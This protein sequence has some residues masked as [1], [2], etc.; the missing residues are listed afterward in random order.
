MKNITIKDI[1]SMAGTSKTTVSFYLNGKSDRMST[2]T[3]LKIEKIIRE[4]NYS[5]SF[6]ARS[7]TYK[8]TNL[9]GVI[10]ADIC[11]P[12]SSAIVKEID[13]AARK[14][15]YQIIVGSSKF[16]F[17]NEEKYINKMLDMGV[18]GFIIQA[19][20]KFSKF[21]DKI[22]GQGK[23]LLLLDSVNSNFKGSFVKINNFDITKEAIENLIYKGYNNFILLTRNPKISMTIQERKKAFTETLERHK[24]NY[25]V[26]LIDD[27]I[28]RENI[29]KAIDNTLKKESK[30]LIFTVDGEILQK[31]YD[32]IKDKGLNIPNEVGI[33]G[34][35]DRRWTY[36]ANPS[37]TTISQPVHDEGK[38]AARILI[39]MIEENKESLK[40]FIF[41]CNINW[42]ESTNLKIKDKY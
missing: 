37:V 14:E 4:T 39:N 24:I 3:K 19:T 26:E 18:D 11:S 25:S 22:K 8:R 20:T 12:F 34:F 28:K 36:Y 6:V 21:I 40:S 9:I 35:E 23:K 2:E 13:M 29:K 10:V 32:Y 27:E 30:N 15:G 5:P 38:Y 17:K 31:A 1:A 16:D 42:K 7:L 41:F 33:I